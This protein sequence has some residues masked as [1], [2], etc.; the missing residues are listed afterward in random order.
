M[1]K[2]LK[3]DELDL[4]RSRKIISKDEIALWVG[5][6]VVAENVCTRKRRV[7]EVKHV[8]AESKRRVLKG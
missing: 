2:L 3:E 5:D 8:L 6:L 4:L 1:E 7:I